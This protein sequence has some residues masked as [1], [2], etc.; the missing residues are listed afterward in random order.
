MRGRHRLMGLGANKPPVARA[1]VSPRALAVSQAVMESV[2]QLKQHPLLRGVVADP[3]KYAQARERASSLVEAAADMAGTTTLG[4]EDVQQLLTGGL[5]I[6]ARAANM[7][8]FIAYE[9]GTEWRAHE[10]R[11]IAAIED[12]A[13]RTNELAAEGQRA[14]SLSGLG[15]LVFVIPVVI[16]LVAYYLGATDAT[17]EA[18]REVCAQNP[19]SAACLRLIEQS[20]PPNLE[21][22]VK[23]V[24]S[25]I[26]KLIFWVGIGAVVLLGGYLIYTFGPAA[27]G[28]A[29]AVRK[30][31]RG[32]RGPTRVWDLDG[33]S[34]YDLE[35]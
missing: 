8:G 33:P 32:M 17:V 3:V 18:M 29:Q 15:F 13:Q 19:E 9:Q 12:L 21:N 10:E 4:S 16:G 26:G 30:R 1:V 20:G 34:T 2:K 22:L 35:V 6:L 7:L 14:G 5:N 24:S 27:G 31:S 11:L 28:A 23:P 25:E